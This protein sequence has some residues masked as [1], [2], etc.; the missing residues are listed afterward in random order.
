M[1]PKEF[2]TFR[3]RLGKTQ[4]Q[5]SELLGTSLRAVQSFEQG[6]RKV[7]VHV[8]RQVLLLAALK[9]GTENLRPCWEVRS[10]S[11]ETRQACP[12]WE[13]RAGPLCWLING[14]ICQGKV[15]GTWSK[16]MKVCRKCRVFAEHVNPG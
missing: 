9:R 13:F 1:T 15:Q 8:E 10:C 5:M 11:P 2:S 3:Q 14:T 6:W 16:K 4:K 7:P 12:A